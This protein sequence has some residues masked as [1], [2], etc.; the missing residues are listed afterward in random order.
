MD[1]SGGLASHRDFQHPPHPRSHAMPHKG[2]HR[3]G[4]IY[5]N[6]ADSL[7]RVAEYGKRDIETLKEFFDLRRTA[8][9]YDKRNRSLKHGFQMGE[10]VRARLAAERNE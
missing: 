7:F 1:H 3:L 6:I 8:G 10:I 9:G 2:V 5:G 4:S